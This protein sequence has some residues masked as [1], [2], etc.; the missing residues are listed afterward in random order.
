MS[1]VSYDGLKY[2]GGFMKNFFS[3]S[4][5]TTI[6]YIVALIAFIGVGIWYVLNKKVN[7][8]GIDNQQSE[9]Q[10]LNL[11]DWQTYR[12]EEYGFEIKC[13]TNFKCKY[14]KLDNWPLNLTMQDTQDKLLF[15][16][17]EV[18]TERDAQLLETQE[19]QP[20][21]PIQF[22]EVPSVS[23]QKTFERFILS[24]Q[25]YEGNQTVE[26]TSILSTSCKKEDSYLICYSY[27]AESVSFSRRDIIYNNNIRYEFNF[28]LTSEGAYDSNEAEQ[29]INKLLSGDLSQ[30]DKK[31]LK[32]YLQTRDSFKFTK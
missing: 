25:I 29:Q 8:Q 30:R 6:V 7:E 15:I 17:F 14:N 4:K 3:V 13:P 20:Y 26:G 12:N 2:K 9:I 21:F 10:N 22:L 32:I 5:R 18:I 24:K 28:T 11:A 19:N 27:N 16:G 31:N 23:G 1:L